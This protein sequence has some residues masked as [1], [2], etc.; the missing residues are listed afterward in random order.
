M[1]DNGPVGIALERDEAL[2]LFEFLQRVLED[3]NGEGLREA[4]EDDAE[5]WALNAVMAVLE[6]SLAEPFA[7]GFE[8][9]LKA[10][11][12][13]VRERSGAWPWDAGEG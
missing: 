3:E 6:R 7:P 4:I 5:L 8:K 10:A 1:A 12:K 9:L 2:V 11:K 13:A